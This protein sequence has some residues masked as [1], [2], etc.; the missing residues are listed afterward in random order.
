LHP[1]GRSRSIA[2][3]RGWD[4]A[5]A[6]YKSRVR[7]LGEGVLRRNEPR[8]PRIAMNRPLR[9]AH[10][11]RPTTQVKHRD[12]DLLTRNNRHIGVLVVVEVFVLGRNLVDPRGDV[13]IER[14][15]RFNRA[16]IHPIHV[17]IGGV[18][19]LRGVPQTVEPD[20]GL[21]WRRCRNLR[22]GRG[23]TSGR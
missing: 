22:C 15:T 19:A 12:E 8:I 23:G 20:P 11:S 13:A 7:D 4:S 21:T 2:E 3:R 5:R 16:E 6:R 10:G 18:E 1:A 9:T 14:A 17:D